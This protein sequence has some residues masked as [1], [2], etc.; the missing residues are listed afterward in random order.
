MISSSGFFPDGKWNGMA[1]ALKEPGTGEQVVESFATDAF[2]AALRS[3]SQ[4]M[5]DE[6]I[7]EYSKGFADETRRNGALELYRS[8]DFSEL[9]RYELAGLGV[10]VLLVW[11]EQDEFSPV[12]GAHRFKRELPHTEL[13]V[14]EGAGHFVWEDAPEE[15]AKA[16]TGFLARVRG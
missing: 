9:E 4:G 11:G 1:K 14:I 6:A 7:R 10:P 15:C 16:L 3:T 12:A 13:V 5:T 2:G 8:G